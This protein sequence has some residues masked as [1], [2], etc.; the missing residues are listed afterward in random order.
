MKVVA[1]SFTLNVTLGN[2]GQF[3]A[4]ALFL[5]QIPTI[6]SVLHLDLLY[7]I[8]VVSNVVVDEI[9]ALHVALAPF[10]SLAA[11][12]L[13]VDLEDAV[14][15]AHVGQFGD[16]GGVEATFGIRQTDP[17]SVECPRDA[18]F[19]QLLGQVALAEDFGVGADE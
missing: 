15:G 10:P 14:A 16:F 7:A 17:V 11:P 19:A 5:P 4:L 18:I 12:L 3:L 9:L 6:K 8:D 13:A 1:Q 2:V